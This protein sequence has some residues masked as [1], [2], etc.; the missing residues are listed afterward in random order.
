VRVFIAVIDDTNVV[1]RTY[2]RWFTTAHN[3]RPCTQM[4]LAFSSTALTCMC[5]L[6]TTHTYN[7]YHTHNRHTYHI[8]TTHRYHTHIHTT[9]TYTHTPHKHTHTHTH[10]T[11][12]HTYH[13]HSK[14]LKLK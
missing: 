10:I 4:S 2:V 3:F 9:H 1:S 14:L 5:T 11:H 8:H 6:Y 12:A 13:T 7:T